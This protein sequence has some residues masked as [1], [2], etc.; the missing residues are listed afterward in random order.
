MEV[1]LQ[2][3]ISSLFSIFSIISG[4]LVVWTSMPLLITFKC[5]PPALIPFIICKLTF[6]QALGHLPLYRCTA[7]TLNSTYAKPNP[8]PIFSH[9]K[10]APPFIFP[11][12]VNRSMTCKSASLHHL[13]CFPVLHPHIHV[14]IIIIFWPCLQHVEV[15]R[16]G[17]KSK[18]QQ[19]PEPLQWQQWILNLLCHKGTPHV[20]CVN[21]TS[22]LS[23]TDYFYHG[24]A[25]HHLVYIS[26]AA[27]KLTFD[28]QILPFSSPFISLLQFSQAQVQTYQKPTKNHQRLITSTNR[29]SINLW[30]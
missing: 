3:T 12:Y 1:F 25:R 30:S 13:W 2:D 21:P 4:T 10:S 6:H 24:G 8:W 27:S 9:F 17:T 23:Y 16:P 15:P 5:T 11:N 29:T 19:W 28:F 18:P 22:I 7:I 20:N 26:V 14:I